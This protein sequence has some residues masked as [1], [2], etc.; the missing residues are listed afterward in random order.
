LRSTSKL[1]LPLL[2]LNF[3][4][5]IKKIGEFEIPIRLFKDVTAAVK[6]K[7]EPENEA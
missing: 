5:F 7:V 4:H 3:L 2:R 1:P 6:L